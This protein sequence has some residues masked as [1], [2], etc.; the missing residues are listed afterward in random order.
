MRCSLREFSPSA[1][2]CGFGNIL[3]HTVE[4]TFQKA[5]KEYLQKNY[6]AAAKQIKKGAA[7]MKTEADKATAKGKEGLAASAKELDQ[8]ADDTKKGAVTSPR[9]INGIE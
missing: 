5:K 4:Q 2:H 3:V 6:D 8:L 1:A 9:R 7:Y